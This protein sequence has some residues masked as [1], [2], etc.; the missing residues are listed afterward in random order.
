M[1]VCPK[2]S[3]ENDNIAVY[4]TECG[5]ELMHSCCSCGAKNK[6]D[7]KHCH[8]CGVGILRNESPLFSC[9]G[10]GIGGE[11]GKE[12]CVLKLS[13][14][15]LFVVTSV[16]GAE[17]VFA[18]N[19][20]NVNKV[21]YKGS[22]VHSNKGRYQLKI[23]T[24]FP[25]KHFKFVANEGKSF[26]KQLKKAKKARKKRPRPH[27]PTKSIAQNQTHSLSSGYEKVKTEKKD[28][29]KMPILLGFFCFCT[30]F[31]GVIIWLVEKAKYPKKAR[32]AILL[33]IYPSLMMFI[34]PGMTGSR[35][36]IVSQNEPLSSPVSVQDYPSNNSPTNAPQ[37]DWWQGGTLHGAT[38]LEWQNASYS[39]KLATCG[40]IM[41]MMWQEGNLSPRLS[42]NIDGM[43][44]LQFWADSLV[45]CL[46][47]A[48][49]RLPDEEQNRILYANQTVPDMASYILLMS[50]WLK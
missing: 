42:N 4:C 23:A 27:Q 46:D 20:E 40:D 16:T 48:M 11:L 44:D 19:L 9:S 47:T 35:Q 13:N 34:L 10:V 37:Q 41:C 36:N 25:K 22:I 17:H 14:E 12:R 24:K 1:V 38:A 39:N 18:V 2:C 15:R 6:I 50:D 32:L 45:I 8:A 7:Q 5:A 29:S 21:D 30:P 31:L 28:P 49:E 26:A 43:A 33:S 3:L